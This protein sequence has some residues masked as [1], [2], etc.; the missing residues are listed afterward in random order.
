MP[1]GPPVDTEAIRPRKRQ[2]AEWGELAGNADAIAVLTRAQLKDFLGKGPAYALTV[3]EVE[4]V[5]KED[6]FWGYSVKG[7]APSARSFLGPSIVEGDVI[8]RVN[9]IRPS[10][11]DEYLQAWQS[12]HNV[13][14]IR[15][16]I[17]RGE[18]ARVVS[19]TVD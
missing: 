8:T 7:I 11:P 12:L 16:D 19:W 18:E 1:A 17:V 14:L 2:Q 3:I 9:G 6:Q 13:S 5:R 15:V 4:P 10:N